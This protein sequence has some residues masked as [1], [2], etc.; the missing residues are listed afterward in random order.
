[1]AAEME[2]LVGILERYPEQL[3]GRERVGV[4]SR[5]LKAV[6]TVGKREA[7]VRMCGVMRKQW[8]SGRADDYSVKVLCRGL[9]D[10]GESTL[11]D[12]VERDYGMTKV[13]P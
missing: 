5:I 2:E 11:A 6:N 3:E 1:M 4:W 10:V 13:W 9:R 12:E 7:V 8:G